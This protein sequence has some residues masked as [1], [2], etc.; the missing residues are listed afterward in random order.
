MPVL[1]IVHI[2]IHVSDLERS[3]AFYEL[4][5]WKVI[6]ELS[7]HSAN[8]ME[9][10]AVSPLNVHGGG[11]TKGVILSLGD[12]P[13]QATKLE[14]IQYVDPAPIARGFRPAQTTG[15]HRIAMRVKH[16][17]DMVADL[18]AKGASIP[19]DPRDMAVMGSRQRY[20]LLPDPD[21][22]IIELIELF[23]A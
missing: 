5:G 8:Y 22:N 9:P 11:T 17:D 2:N 10:V 4:L 12:D 7:R 3:I 21:E 19:D 14:L 1:N 15:V 18:R 20:A 6:H 23:R 16:I 13:R